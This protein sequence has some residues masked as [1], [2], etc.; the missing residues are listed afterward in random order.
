MFLDGPLLINDTPGVACNN[1]AAD[2]LFFKTSALSAVLLLFP[3]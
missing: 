2:I 1:A 3:F